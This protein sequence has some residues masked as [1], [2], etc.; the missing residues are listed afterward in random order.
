MKVVHHLK[1]EDRLPAVHNEVPGRIKVCSK[2][3]V[4]VPQNHALPMLK[5]ALSDCSRVDEW[6]PR[7]F[8]SALAAKRELMVLATDQTVEMLKHN[9]IAPFK[10]VR[11]KENFVFS[12]TYRKASECLSQVHHLLQSPP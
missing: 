1:P 10:F 4:F 6:T 2:S 9:L 12:F 8:Q 5:F 11:G 3:L 7:S